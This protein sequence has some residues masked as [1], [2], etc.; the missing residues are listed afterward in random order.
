MKKFKT[1]RKRR[2]FKLFIYLLIVLISFNI[3]LNILEKDIKINPEKY[4]KYLVNTGFN[5]QFKD[6]KENAF[7]P[8]SLIEKN[9]NFNITPQNTFEN[10]SIKYIEQVNKTMDDA[11]IYI[12]NTH[13]SEEYKLEYTYEYSVKPN[14]KL[15][16]YILQENL[17]N[18]NIKSI[19]ETTPI[20]K[21]LKENNYI[22]KDSYKA[23][24]IL[25]EDIKEKYPSIK[26]F[27]DIHRDS[28]KKEKTTLIYN[29]KKY[30]KT[31][32]IV[33][34]EH[35]NY[36]NNLDNN[37]I[38]NNYINDIVPSISRG[39]YKK[40]G[41]GVNGIYNQDFNSNVIVIEVGGQDNTIEEV[42]NTLKVLSL[43]INNYIKDGFYEKEKL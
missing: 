2:L 3:T 17:N 12:Y 25:L 14:V 19:V 31:M 32:L 10:D 39:I 8:I 33:G 16:S 20:S 4:I 27:I 43:A 5:N 28:S 11:L 37:T 23:S 42:S 36:Q 34:L 21:I 13:D 18:L 6:F 7:S 35:Q 22:Y 9:L 38:L 26:L 1:K 24:R 29:D 15:A 30:A 41:I 40:E